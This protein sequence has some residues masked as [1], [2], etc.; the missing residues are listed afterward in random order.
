MEK[1][2]LDKTIELKIRTLVLEVE[3]E[4]TEI[5]IW[6]GSRIRNRIQEQNIWLEY[7]L[8]STTEFDIHSPLQCGLNMYTLLVTC[9]SVTLFVS[10]VKFLGKNP[11]DSRKDI[12][13][14][15]I[16]KISQKMATFFL[17]FE[18][19]KNYRK[20][21]AKLFFLEN[22]KNCWLELTN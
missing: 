3:K 19:K 12:K 8:A 6:A 10:I 7:G 4:N 9:Q 22:K 18:T 16:K 20:K 5:F 2:I 14:V 21:F 13:V 1:K 11:Y 17:I 15:R